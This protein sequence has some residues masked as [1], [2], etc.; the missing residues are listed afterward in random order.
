MIGTHMKEHILR[1][2]IL[3]VMTIHTM[4]VVILILAIILINSSLHK[5]FQITLI[6]SQLAIQLISRLNQT[7]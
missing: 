3:V 6:Q 1:I 4:I 2:I 7:I 5:V